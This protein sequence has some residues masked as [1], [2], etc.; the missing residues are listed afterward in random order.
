M[1]HFYTQE[2]VAFL[3]ENI[4]GRFIRD[5][6]RLFNARFQL[7]CS[8]EQIKA[9]CANRGLVNGMDGR[10]PPGHIPANKG[11]KGVGGWKP[12]QFKKGHRPANYLPVG[13]E[14]PDPDDYIKVKIGEPDKWRH[15]HLLIWEAANGPLPPGH[16]V[17]FADRDNRNF[18]LD[19]LVKV[20]RAELLYLNRHGLIL[21]DAELTKTAVNVAS[22]ATAVFD[23]LRPARPPK[24]KARK[25]ARQAQ[26]EP[27]TKAERPPAW[28]DLPGFPGYQVNRRGKVR[29]T[30]GHELS[31][32]G[33][34]Y[35]LSRAG[36]RIKVLFAELEALVAGEVKPAP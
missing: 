17:I 2:Q 8:Y 16:A 31:P 21:E 34:G 27:A 15:K 28:R 5:L 9:A 22:L 35:I 7:K 6:T 14:V 36:L 1:A 29:T 25:T 18:S 24:E 12:T 23:K 13:A 26:T 32:Q 20:T 3:K 19:N 33:R 4:H 30:T 11:L 10:F